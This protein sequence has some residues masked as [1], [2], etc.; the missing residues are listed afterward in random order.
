MLER[1]RIG[2]VAIE[3]RILLRLG[4]IV[5]VLLLAYYLGP[6]A[7]ERFLVLS[8]AAAGVLV[9]IRRLEL[10]LVALLIGALSVPFTISTGTQTSLNP[11][12]LLPPALLG[13]WAIE[14]VRRQDVR[15]VPS[16]VNL[17]LIAFV[18]SAT[19]SFVG[20]NIQWNLWASSASLQAQLGGWI[21]FVLSAGVFLLVGNQVKDIRWLKVL[22]G[23]FLGV[24]ALYLAGRALPYASQ[25]TGRLLAAGAAGSLFWVWLVAL[26]GGQALFNK[27]ISRTERVALLGLVLLTLGV[28]WFQGRSWASGWAP[29][30][31]ALVALLWLR[32]WRLG[33]LASLVVGVAF[34]WVRSQGAIFATMPVAEQ[35]L[36]LL[37]VSES[38]PNLAASV[39][40]ED[41]YSID[42]RW[43]AWDI[44]VNK[45]LP[46]NPILGL[47]PSNYY[48]HTRLYPIL[49]WYVN[50]NSHSQYVDILAQTGMLGLATFVWLMATISK[51]GWTLRET[52]G[53]GFARGYVYG[54]LAGLAGTLAAGMLGDWFLPFV[55]N[56]GL[57]GFRASILGWLFL[58]GLVALQGLA[59]RRSVGA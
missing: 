18:A 52:V 35:F 17:P 59:Q 31:A 26:A 40:V 22:T 36:N 6:R 10:G 12:V 57:A 53:N 5:G 48:H 16:P 51:L 55:Y 46:A 19:L 8:I 54:C 3:E 25:V 33:L 15:L 13:V 47:G 29:P 20:G 4:I 43:I 1:L 21:V 30:L 14:M 56:I 11:A 32:S 27:S 24:G 2:R 37:G 28:G 44:V 41:Q 49:G 38:D 9:L 50:F 45:V 42:T 7:S 34:V 58:G 39:I 23:I